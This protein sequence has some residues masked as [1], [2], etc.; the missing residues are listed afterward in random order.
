[1]SSI[2]GFLFILFISVVTVLGDFFIKLASST[3]KYI[4]IRYFL[5]GM[6]LYLLTGVGWFFAMRKIELSSIGAIYGVTTVILLA[7]IGVLFFRENLS[8]VESIAILMGVASI[9]M[10]IRFAS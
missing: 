8:I 3:A 6:F 7:L 9:F 10:L 5:Y 4:D 1:M 2:T